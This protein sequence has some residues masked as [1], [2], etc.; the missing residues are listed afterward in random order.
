MAGL[1]QMGDCIQTIR[2]V[3]RPRLRDVIQH[4]EGAVPSLVESDTHQIVMRARINIRTCSTL[5]SVILVTLISVWMTHIL[6][7]QSLLVR[8]SH[9]Q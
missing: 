2:D 6:L 1:T 9:I 3:Q 5:K 7:S 4:I 8:S